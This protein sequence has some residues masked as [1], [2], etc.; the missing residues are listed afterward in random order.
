MGQGYAECEM[1]RDAD[2]RAIDYR[3][4]EVNP[5]FE[6]LTGIPAAD[7][8][9]RTVREVVPGIEDWWIETYARIVGNGR[10]ERVEYEAAPLGRWYEVHAYP[11]GGDRF[12]ALYEDITER[13]RI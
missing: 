13:K 12:I 8:R 3:F 10:P 11:Q 9:G 7:A 6:R 5:A 4:V 1:I 2:G